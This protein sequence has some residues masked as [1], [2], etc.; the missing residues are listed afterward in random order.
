MIIQLHLSH[1]D[2]T[3]ATKGR[4]LLVVN[5]PSYEVDGFTVVA[6]FGS[7]TVIGLHLIS[8]FFVVKRLFKQEIEKYLSRVKFRVRVYQL[9][10]ISRYISREKHKVC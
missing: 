10:I 9:N 3:Q 2:L 8:S 1:T 5:L 4:S 6:S 7:K